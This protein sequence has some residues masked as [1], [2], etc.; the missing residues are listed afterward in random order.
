VE[1]AEELACRYPVSQ[2]QFTLS[3]TQASTEAIRLARAVTG[4]EV[5]VLFQGHYHGHF[6]EGLAD[7]ADGQAG[8]P[9]PVQRGLAKGVTGR[10]RIAPVQRSRHATGRARAG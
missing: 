8:G 5:I 4:R 1:V 10:V 2:W 9:S 6:E 3:A 7:L